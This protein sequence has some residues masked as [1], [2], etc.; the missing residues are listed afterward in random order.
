MRFFSIAGFFDLVPLGL[1]NPSYPNPNLTVVIRNKN[2]GH[3]T[4]H[5][6]LDISPGIEFR[7]CCAFMYRATAWVRRSISSLEKMLAM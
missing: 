6:Y 4:L 5:L 2:S 7:C 1:K 3:K